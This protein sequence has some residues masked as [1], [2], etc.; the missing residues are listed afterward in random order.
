MWSTNKRYFIL[1]NT[2]FTSFKKKRS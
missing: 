1:C 2:L